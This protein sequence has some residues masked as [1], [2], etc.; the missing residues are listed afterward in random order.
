MICGNCENGEFCK[1]IDCRFNN[2]CGTSCTTCVKDNEDFDE[3][4]NLED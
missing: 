4:E 3:L 2:D 1:C